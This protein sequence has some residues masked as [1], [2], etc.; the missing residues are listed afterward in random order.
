MRLLF[1]LEYFPPHIGGV[2]TLFDN[3]TKRLV[4]KGFDVDIY[5]SLVEGSQRFEVSEG[6]RIFRE[7]LP[8]RH[9]FPLRGFIPTA[10]L[11]RK[12]DLIHTTSFSA[13][14]CTALAEI[15]TKK[16]TVITIHEVWDRLW[17]ELENPISASV[18]YALESAM[19]KLYKNSIITVPSEYTKRAIEEKIR[20]AHPINVIPH[21][22]EHEIFNTKVKPSYTF[23]F[24][25]YMFHGRPGISK[26][27]QYIFQAMPLI[28]KEVPDAKFLMMVSKRQRAAYNIMMRQAEKFGVEDKIMFIEPRNSRKEIA[29]VIKSVD[30][31][32]IP[33][34][35]EGFCFSAV[36]AQAVG[37]PVVASKAGSLPEVVRGGLFVEP[38]N[39]QDI[40]EKV[41]KLLTN[42]KLNNKLGKAGSKFVKKF[43]WDRAVDKYIKLYEKM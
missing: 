21:G 11:A 15:F 32:V 41:T 40:A 6:R 20:P 33:S 1:V 2:E 42:K 26:G 3:L 39:A 35:S 38:R 17:F 7:P 37:T 16:P 5:T 14:G 25:T 29:S 18:N 4:E 12:A 22:I 13:A 34:L 10:R 28:E 36:E 19:C 43:T 8:F 23:D 24:P 9:L 30:C 27:L 31:C